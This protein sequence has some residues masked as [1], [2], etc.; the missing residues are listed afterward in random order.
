M[1]LRTGCTAVATLP[2]ATGMSMAGDVGEARMLEAAGADAAATLCTQEKR[3][4]ISSNSSVCSS[5]CGMRRCTCMRQSS[6]ADAKPRS[7]L[8]HS[9]KT[10]DKA[11]RTAKDCIFALGGTT[12]ASGLGVI[13]RGA[14]SPEP[15]KALTQC[16]LCAAYLLDRQ[17]A[18]V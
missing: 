10:L 14:A 12:R 6:D 17:L 4:K 11:D 18:G 16:R 3:V 9:V 1:L 2:L 7:L 5:T 8:C 15:R 13:A